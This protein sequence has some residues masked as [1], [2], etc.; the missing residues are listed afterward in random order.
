VGVPQ[1][2][3]PLP[4]PAS[5]AAPGLQVDLHLYLHQRLHLRHHLHLQLQLRALSLAA[6]RS[7]APQDTYASAP[8]VVAEWRSAG[9]GVPARSRCRSCIPRWAER[10]RAI[11]SRSCWRLPG[12]CARCTRA[13]GSS[14]RVGVGAR[15]TWGC[16]ATEVTEEEVAGADGRLARRL[17]GALSCTNDGGGALRA[18]CAR[19]Q[20]S[21][22]RMRSAF[23]SAAVDISRGTQKVP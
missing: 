20:A 19:I 16:W 23:A 11:E 7:H 6:R 12:L 10:R 4:A 21:I 14:L 15:R 13:D 3:T 2:P 8:A 18:S 17:G 5:G 9:G 22:E 1:Q